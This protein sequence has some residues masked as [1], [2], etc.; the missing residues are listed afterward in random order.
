MNFQHLKT[1]CAVLS[2][3]SMTA[4]SQKLFLTQPA[5]SQQIRNLEEELGAVLL[6]RGVRQVKATPQG[7]I[8]YEYAHRILNL[9]EQSKIA[10][11]TV[12]AEVSGVLRIGTLNSIGL[13]LI[14]PIFELFLKSNS[15]VR[16]QLRY[17]EG[18]DVIKMLENGAVDAAILP[19]AENEYGSDP[20]DCQKE[21][22][23]ADEMW[24][25]GSLKDRKLP[26]SILL[27][28]YG[29]RPIVH[30][31]Q[32]YTGFEKLLTKELKKRGVTVHPVFESSNVGTLKR[33]IESGLGWGFLPAHSVR[34]QV[35]TGRMQ[36][37][38]IEDFS[39]Y[40]DMYCY[41]PKTLKV[42]KNLEVFLKA[43]QQPTL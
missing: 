34:K 24:L 40:L 39:Y 12:S 1:F 30:L 37:I 17:A 7:Q 35:S 31:T 10:I 14:G 27:K 23:G 36:R 15:S 3:K 20:E 21:P 29:Q 13:Y 8:L 19:H 28:D 6:V 32:E 43:V 18:A 22:I 4:A 16:L 5:V 41:F 9:V 2:E 33:M 25:V 26:T 38:Q 11:Q 42:A